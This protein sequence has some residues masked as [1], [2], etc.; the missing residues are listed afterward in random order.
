[1]GNQSNGGNQVQSS[2]ADPFGRILLKRATLGMRGGTNIC[3]LCLVSSITRTC[4]MFFT[5]MLRVFSLDVYGLLH[6]G[7]ILSFVTPYVALQFQTCP[8]LPLETFYVL[9]VS[10]SQQKSL[11]QFYHLYYQK[12]IMVDLVEFDMAYFDV[13]LGMDQLY[14]F[15]PQSIVVLKQSSFS[16]LMKQFQSGNISNSA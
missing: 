10:L 13:I 8:E 12:D 6:L 3:I 16:F 7:V 11:L 4:Q 2:S 5:C 15:M 14:V 1:M 9:V